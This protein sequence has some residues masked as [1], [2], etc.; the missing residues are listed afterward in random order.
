MWKRPQKNKKTLAQVMEIN[1][2]I[3]WMLINKTKLTKNKSQLQ[4]RSISPSK[5]EAIS[6]KNTKS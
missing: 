5:R 1:P 3:L 2:I 6:N 4:K